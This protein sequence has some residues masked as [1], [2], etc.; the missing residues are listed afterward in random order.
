MA[1]CK[2]FSMEGER[3]VYLVEVDE[4]QCVGCGA[5]A[6]DCPQGVYDLV[7]GVSTVNE[8]ECIGCQTCVAVCPND[9]ITL[10]EY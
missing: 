8:N 9:A 4:S 7:D 10:S 5:C 2:C 1:N 6:S 3:V